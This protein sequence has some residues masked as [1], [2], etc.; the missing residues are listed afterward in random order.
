M[1]V[2]G[3]R[4]V[5]AQEGVIGIEWIDGESVRVLLGAED[6]D[7]DEVDEESDLND[8]EQHDPLANFKT[9]PRKANHFSL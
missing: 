6:E 1:R 9:T 7:A 2:P 8:P 4:M 3:L 5:D